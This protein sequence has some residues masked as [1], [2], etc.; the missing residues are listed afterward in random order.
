LVKQKVK[1]TGMGDKMAEIMS[2]SNQASKQ[3]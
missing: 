3:T 1:E 2:A